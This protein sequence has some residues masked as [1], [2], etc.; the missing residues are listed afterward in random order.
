MNFTLKSQE[1]AIPDFENQNFPGGA[2]PLT[3]LACAG[4]RARLVKWLQLRHWLHLKKWETQEQ[5][6]PDLDKLW[7]IQIAMAIK[8]FLYNM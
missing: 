3:P 7:D 1:M 6:L 4:L 8:T 5:G 2:C